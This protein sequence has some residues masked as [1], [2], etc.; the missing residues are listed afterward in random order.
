MKKL[1][2]AIIVSASH[3][4]LLAAEP[5]TRKAGSELKEISLEELRQVEVGAVPAPR[6]ENAERQEPA[7]SENP[8]AGYLE[9]EVGDMAK[10]YMGY[11]VLESREIYEGGDENADLLLKLR[12]NSFMARGV[13]MTSLK[14]KFPF[15]TVCNV[16]LKTAPGREPS[17]VVFLR[18][19]TF[20]GEA[21]AKEYQKSLSAEGT[22]KVYFTVHY[23]H[24]EISESPFRM[25]SI[26]VPGTAD[27]G[28]AGAR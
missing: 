27:S 28:A 19:R 7:L 3:A 10:L 13:L 11:L 26:A 22:A 24:R 12:G 1:L 5:E 14:K 21:A 18:S 4:A 8:A 9:M 16:Y 23:N 2:I 20:V 15:Q 25:H 6:P 17:S